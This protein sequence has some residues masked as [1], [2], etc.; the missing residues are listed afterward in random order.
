[1]LVRAEMWFWIGSSIGA[2]VIVHAGMGAIVVNL[3]IR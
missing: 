1:M 2:S 3:G